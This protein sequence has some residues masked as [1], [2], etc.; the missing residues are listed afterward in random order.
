VS[1][2]IYGIKGY[3]LC[4]KTSLCFEKYFICY[5]R[6]QAHYFKV[7][8]AMVKNDIFINKYAETIKAVADAFNRHDI[9]QL[10]S[11]CDHDI[12]WDDPAMEE[13]V[14][15]HNM[16]K[17]FVSSLLEAI[18]NVQYIPLQD[19][20]FSPEQNKIAHRFIMRGTML[21]KMPPGFF[22]TGR[23]FEIDGLEMIEFRDGKLYQ[24]ITRIDGLNTAEQLGLLP[25]RLKSG[26]WKT[27]I[28]CFFQRLIA[29]YLRRYTKKH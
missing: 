20:F 4:T 29:W 11:F 19:I 24:V 27:K 10:L 9:E 13:P 17:D 18:P 1:I 8:R 5:S 6:K 22:P 3:K 7:K 16:L 14:R 12:Y 21:G 28:V 25:P 2:A 26:E 23:Q 15:G